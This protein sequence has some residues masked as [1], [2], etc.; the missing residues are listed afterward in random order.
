M[1]SLVQKSSVIPD[2]GETSYWDSFFKGRGDRV[3]E[4]Y[5]EFEDLKE[6]LEKYIRKNDQILVPGCGSSTLSEGIYDSLDFGRIVNIDTSD[7]VIRQMSSRNKRSGMTYEKRNAMETGYDAGSFSVIVDKGTLD[8]IA[9]DASEVSLQSAKRL[10]QEYARVLKLGGRC[11]IISLLQDHILRLVCEFFYVTEG[12]M[13]RFHRSKLSEDRQLYD[14]PEALAMPVFAVVATKFKQSPGF[15]P[16][17]IELVLEA[18]RSLKMQD[19][20][21]EV[22][23]EISKLQ[24]TA[25]ARHNAVR[26]RLNPD[27]ELS[28]EIVDKYG[29][30]RFELILRDRRPNHISNGSYGIYIVPQGHTKEGRADLV[31]AAKFDRLLIVHLQRNQFYDSYDTIKTELS[32]QVMRLCGKRKSREQPSFLTDGDV[33]NAILRMEGSS[34]KSGEFFVQDSPADAENAN[35]SFRRLIFR[36]NCNLIQSEVL[37]S[38]DQSGSKSENFD[39]SNLCCAHHTAAVGGF[40]LLNAGNFSRSCENL[41]VLIIGLGGGCLP[42][43]LSRNFTSMKIDVVDFDPEMRNVAKQWFGFTETAN[44]KVIIEDGIAFLRNSAASGREYDAIIFDVNSDDPKSSLRCPPSAFVGN[45]VLENVR[46]CLR[47]EG[48]FMMNLASRDAE[49]RLKI[50]RMMVTKFD[51]VFRVPIAEEIN[52]MLFCLKCE[53]DLL[54]LSSNN[55]SDFCVDEENALVSLAKTRVSVFIANLESTLASISSGKKK[56]RRKRKGKGE[57]TVEE[58]MGSLEIDQ[59]GEIESVPV[60]SAHSVIVKKESLESVAMVSEDCQRKRNGK[61]KPEVVTDN[62]ENISSASKRPRPAVIKSLM[63]VFLGLEVVRAT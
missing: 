3:F 49:T 43:F 7:V 56:I 19:G 60:P 35:Y 52:V 47:P 57:K 61:A 34:E 48:I 33:V 26:R 12:W 10:C 15:V 46:K 27:E 38:R 36:S 22:Q 30:R 17:P 6:V 62:V 59:G 11:I 24:M 20:L 31:E 63:N 50:G 4:W 14:N 23:R 42:M 54:K 9:N 29:D 53:G 8:A 44:M 18:G 40:G 51:Q 25:Y 1:S 28:F 5:G 55:P 39:F 13:L 32:G 37:L 2:F 45:S 58:K 41:S 21:V 16:P